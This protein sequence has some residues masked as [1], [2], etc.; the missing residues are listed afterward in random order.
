MA[1]PSRKRRRRKEEKGSRESL[2]S[3]TMSLKV[4]NADHVSLRMCFVETGAKENRLIKVRRGGTVLPLFL[5]PTA[6]Q[7]P[8]HPPPA[9]FS[10]QPQDFPSVSCTLHPVQR[11]SGWLRLHRVFTTLQVFVS[12]S[13]PLVEFSSVIIPRHGAV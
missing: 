10:L 3:Q 8:T 11:G 1:P 9:S 13:S 7:P 6:T 12:V 5:W 2:T 4:K